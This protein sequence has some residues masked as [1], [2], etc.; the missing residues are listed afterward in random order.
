MLSLCNSAVRLTENKDQA[1]VIDVIRF[2]THRNAKAASNSLDRVRNSCPEIDA[3]IKQYRFPNSNMDTPVASAPTLV[4]IIWALPGKTAKEI[5]IKCANE[6]CR[7]LGADPSLT[8]DLAIRNISASSEEKSFFLA[9]VQSPTTDSTLEEKEFISKKRK[10]EVLNLELDLTERKQ[11]ITECNMNIRQK[12]LQLYERTMQIEL[13]KNDA[14]MQSL[15]RDI[16]IQTFSGG[17]TIA[18]DRKE[19]PFPYCADFS[20]ILQKMGRRPTP[21]LLS[22]LGKYIAKEYRDAFQQEPPTIPKYVAGANRLVKT[23][24][25]QHE[26]WLREKISNFLSSSR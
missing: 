21:P 6:I 7:L 11:R 3:K 8:K 22:S 1:S 10:L 4:Q 16:I 23:Y 24:P 9:H 18:T 26:G 2:T 5:R 19:T 20:D 25:I 13:F 12:S 15:A 14:H 17:S